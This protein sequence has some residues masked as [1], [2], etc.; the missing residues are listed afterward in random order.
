[1]G[2]LLLGKISDEFYFTH[3]GTTFYPHNLIDPEDPIES[4]DTDKYVDIDE[5]RYE[6]LAY[7]YEIVNPLVVPDKEE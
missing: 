3:G 4:I 6:Q 5:T 1:M 7:K 2:S